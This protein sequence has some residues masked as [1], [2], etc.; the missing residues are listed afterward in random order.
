M[1]CCWSLSF[2]HTYPFHLMYFS[3]FEIHFL[4][5]LPFRICLRACWF[6]SLT[7]IPVA[8]CKWAGKI[9]FYSATTFYQ[10]TATELPEHQ[11]IGVKISLKKYF[12]I[13]FFFI[14]SFSHSISTFKLSKLNFIKRRE[15]ISSS[16]L[17]LQSCSVKVRDSRKLTTGR[18]TQNYSLPKYDTS[19]WWVLLTRRALDI[20][21]NAHFYCYCTIDSL[22]ASA[23][24]SVS[25]RCIPI[26]DR[27]FY[28]FTT[29]CNCYV[30]SRKLAAC[31]WIAVL[32]FERL[33]ESVEKI[34]DVSQLLLI[35]FH[36]I[37]VSSKLE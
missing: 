21:W 18:H 4:F 31:C 14:I 37:P 35:E 34:S 23:T 16:V 20:S 28:N 6:H 15:K 32:T 27:I 13:S 8:N 10:Q 30:N 2:I 36:F 9:D 3:Q 11:T 19:G 22:L 26:I 7:E 17:Q 24:E 1:L 12:N 25:K 33:R 29:I 5:F